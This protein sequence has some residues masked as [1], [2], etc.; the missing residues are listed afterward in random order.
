MD[1]SREAEAFGAEVSFSETAAPTVIGQMAGDLDSVPAPRIPEVGEKRT[2]AHL[3]GIQIVAHRIPDKPLSGGNYQ[4]LFDGRA[5]TGY[6]EPPPGGEA[7]TCAGSCGSGKG[8][9][10][11]DNV[12]R[13]D[14]SGRR[15]WPHYG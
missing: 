7:A 9:R 8:H 6:E 15:Q 1:L 10:V 2:G 4:S 5:A 3:E 12:F 11:S 13:S 14:P